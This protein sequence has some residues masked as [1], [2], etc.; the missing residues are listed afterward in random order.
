VRACSTATA[1]RRRVGVP[2]RA[3]AG[4][5]GN[6]AHAARAH[7]SASEPAG[8]AEGASG[9]SSTGGGDRRRR[10]WC[11][12]YTLTQVIPSVSARRQGQ[13]QH[14]PATLSA[15]IRR[16]RSLG[17]LLLLVG[18][19]PPVPHGSGAIYAYDGDAASP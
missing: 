1:H 9:G 13:Q 10:L 19:L 11:P 17:V 4:R 5:R 12:Y 8:A 6:A 14:R 15:F 2:V 7:G 18:T 16:N 3:I